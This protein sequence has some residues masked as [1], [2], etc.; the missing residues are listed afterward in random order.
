MDRRIAG[1]IGAVSAL[2]AAL[3]AHA[4]SEAPLTIESVMQV[5]S[6]ADLLRPIP[7]AAAL[8]TETDAATRPTVE[9]VQYY[10][11][12]RRR[13][14]HHHDHHHHHHHHHHASA[15]RIIGRVVGQIARQ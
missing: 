13:H 4:A 5:N 2:S 9:D 1:V 15:A 11:H 7:N 3:P 10:Y 14:Y 6:Y 8:L 12:R